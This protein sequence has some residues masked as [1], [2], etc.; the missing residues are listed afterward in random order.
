MLKFLLIIIIVGLIVLFYKMAMEDL[1]IMSKVKDEKD[2][3][4]EEVK[5]AKEEIGEALDKLVDAVED[6]VKE[7]KECCG[8]CCKD[9]NEGCK[10]G[11]QCK[12]KKDE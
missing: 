2:D 8:G 7:E 6:A 5:E 11:G 10:C 1:K 3:F 9:G 4:M 12:C